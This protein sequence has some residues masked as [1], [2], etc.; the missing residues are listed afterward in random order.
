MLWFFLDIKN[1]LWKNGDNVFF[2]SK[3]LESTYF[4]PQ[5]LHL[6]AKI[7]WFLNSVSWD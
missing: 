1:L 5:M 2:I 3:C 4:Y 7:L 6:A